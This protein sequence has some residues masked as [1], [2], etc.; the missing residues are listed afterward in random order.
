MDTPLLAVCK[1]V[2]ARPNK[3][4]LY[5]E[6]VFFAMYA[7]WWLNNIEQKLWQNITYS[8]YIKGY[9]ISLLLINL[10]RLF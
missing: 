8:A 2:S 7:T 4:F 9:S 5:L 10:V 6:S 1:I 3:M